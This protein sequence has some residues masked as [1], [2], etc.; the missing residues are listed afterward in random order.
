[1]STACRCASSRRGRRIL[2]VHARRSEMLREEDRSRIF[3]TKIPH[4]FNT[5]LVD[6]QVAGTWRLEHDAVAPHPVAPTAAG[7]AE[8]ELRD[9]ADRLAAFHR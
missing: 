4:S 8:R 3:D 1:M 9:E 2:L 7:T 6:G 5:F